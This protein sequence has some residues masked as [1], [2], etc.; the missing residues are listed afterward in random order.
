MY[1]LQT[2][3]LNYNAFSYLWGGEAPAHNVL[4]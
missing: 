4:R 2:A 3:C 1:S